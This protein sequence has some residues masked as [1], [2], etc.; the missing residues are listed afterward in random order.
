MPN[1]VAV[2]PATG[3]WT[4]KHKVRLL[5]AVA[6]GKLSLVDLVDAGV[7][8]EEFTGWEKKF[9]ADGRKGLRASL[10]LRHA[11]AQRVDH[12]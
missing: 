4:T 12:G 11:R 5:N 1:K 3:R 10:G 2:L 6:D 9:A 7:S 8:V